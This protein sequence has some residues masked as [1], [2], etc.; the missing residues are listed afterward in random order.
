MTISSWLRTASQSLAPLSSTPRLDAE[1][2]AAFALGI[3]RQELLTYTKEVDLA[4]LDQLLKRRLTGE[5]IAYITGKKEFYGRDFFVS[6][7]VLIPRPD[8]ETLIALALE[9]LANISH[10][11]VLELGT[12]SGCLGLTLAAEN[13]HLTLTATD[14][15]AAALAIARQNATALAVADRVTFKEQ[16]LLAGEN[17]QYDLL[18]ANLPYVPEHWLN[19]SANSPLTRGLPFEPAVALTG[20][21]DGLDVFRRFLPQLTCNF[22]AP[23]VLLEH[24]DNQANALAKLVKQYL[25]DRTVTA[26][27]DLENRDRVTVII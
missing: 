27:Q 25:P 10:P 26:H 8:S 9:H 12:G 22:C 11:R 18:I 7:A 15:S 17:G 14:I 13:P 16:D 2:L 3:T 1:L 23:V 21:E 5:P 24:G 20:G 6:P 4:L 19:A